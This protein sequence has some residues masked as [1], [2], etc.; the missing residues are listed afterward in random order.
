MARPRRQSKAFSEG[1]ILTVHPMARE[2]LLASAA[3][4]N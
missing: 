2:F 4:F 1:T 3:F